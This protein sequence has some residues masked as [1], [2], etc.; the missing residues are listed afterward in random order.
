VTKD[1]K[2]QEKKNKLQQLIAQIHTIKFE[3]DKQSSEVSRKVDSQ[4]PTRSGAIR[5]QQVKAIPPNEP[6]AEKF[7][8]PDLS[9]EGQY[10]EFDAARCRTAE[11]QPV[12]AQTLRMLENLVQSASGL[13]QIENPQQLAEILFLS[14]NLKQ[15][16]IVY[17]Q[18]LNRME[19]NDVSTAVPDQARTEPGRRIGDKTANLLA[20]KAWILFQIGNCLRD[21]DPLTA[22]KM[23]KQLI[24]EYP[25][26]PWA[27]LVKSRISFIDFFLNEKPRDLIAEYMNK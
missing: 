12:S 13:N 21:E 15:A 3:Q 27:D 11:G 10:S 24:T 5:P 16:A 26:C 6:N 25:D 7:N 8:V 9:N 14:G 17:Q 2:E 20:E 4:L 23:Y 22:K 19:P 1:E 18:A